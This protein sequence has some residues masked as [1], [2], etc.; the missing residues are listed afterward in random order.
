M[1]VSLEDR[2]QHQHQTRLDH[3]ISNGRDPQPAEPARRLRDLPFLHRR[4]SELPSL[5]PK[6][7]IGEELPGQLRGLD[8]THCHLVDPSR[9]CPG[10]TGNPLPRQA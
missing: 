9:T 4:G 2:L 10:V 5:H 3:P 1:E 6:A 7:K 8:R